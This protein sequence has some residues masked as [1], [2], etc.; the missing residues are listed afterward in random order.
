MAKLTFILVKYFSK[1]IMTKFLTKNLM[2]QNRL[3]KNTHTTHTLLFNVIYMCQEFE[4]ELRRDNTHYVS[5]LRF[6][7]Y[8]HPILCPSTMGHVT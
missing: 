4:T 1:K 8:T 3:K 5:F 6:A 7:I 2:C